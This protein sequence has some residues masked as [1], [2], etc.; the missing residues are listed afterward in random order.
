LAV[1]C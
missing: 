1:G